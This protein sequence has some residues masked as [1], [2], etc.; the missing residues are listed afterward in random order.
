MDPRNA[1]PQIFP[2][3]S[4]VRERLRAELERLPSSPRA[5]RPAG[6]DERD[7][8]EARRG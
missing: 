3:A 7:A 1:G 2:S 4:Q 8:A 5:G 6:A